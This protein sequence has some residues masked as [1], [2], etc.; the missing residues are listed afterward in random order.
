[1]VPVSLF[2][3]P[4]RTQERFSIIVRRTASTDD[5]ESAIFQTLAPGAYTAIVSG[6]GNLTGVA[7]VDVYR[8]P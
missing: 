6:S 2:H 7:L 8:L 1:M 4:S 5:L 3:S